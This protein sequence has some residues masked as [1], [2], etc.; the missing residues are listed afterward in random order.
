MTHELRS[1]MLLATGLG[2]GAVAFLAFSFHLVLL[3]PLA[4]IMLGASNVIRG[5]NAQRALLEAK[6]DKEL[7]AEDARLNRVIYAPDPELEQKFQKLEEDERAK[8]QCKQDVF[9]ANSAREEIADLFC[10]PLKIIIDNP[11][12]G[13]W[14]SQRVPSPTKGRPLYDR[15]PT[16]KALMTKDL[17]PN[18]INAVIVDGPLLVYLEQGK[19]PSIKIEGSKHRI[20]RLKTTMVDDT[21]TI[22]FPPKADGTPRKSSIRLRVTIRIPRLEKVV[23]ANKATIFVEGMLPALFAWIG[24]QSELFFWGSTPYLVASLQHGLLDTC[25][26]NVTTLVL[27]SCEGSALNTV[28]KTVTGYCMRQ[29]QFWF[30]RLDTQV[31]NLEKGV[32]PERFIA[33]RSATQR[34]SAIQRARRVLDEIAEG[35]RPVP[36]VHNEGSRY[37]V[38]MTKD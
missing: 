28:A 17:L 23:A 1:W 13:W 33:P 3:L 2:G 20:E 16:V 4:I 5:Q 9:D 11:S 34:E 36:Q 15:Q 38:S 22:C 18:T 10:Q 37:Y 12:K 14:V 21:L 26:G 29:N 32:S 35:K 30:P 31:S 24:S 25:G 19:A 6:R 8:N 27:H 7:E